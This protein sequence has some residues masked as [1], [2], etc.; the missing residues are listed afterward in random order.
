MSCKNVIFSG[1]QLIRWTMTGEV[2]PVH[3]WSGHSDM[4]GGLSSVSLRATARWTRPSKGGPWS[5]EKFRLSLEVEKVG[6]P[7]KAGPYWWQEELGSQRRSSVEDWK[8]TVGS[9]FALQGTPLKHRKGTGSCKEITI[10]DFTF[11]VIS[12]YL[13]KT[14]QLHI[15]SLDFACLPG[16]NPRRW[17]HPLSV[18]WLPMRR[19]KGTVSSHI[20]RHL[21]SHRTISSEIDYVL[22]T[23]L[24]LFPS[25]GLLQCDQKRQK[26]LFYCVLPSGNYGERQKPYRNV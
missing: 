2:I 12:Q 25:E 21:P 14:L 11:H 19:L 24:V 1:I 3:H 18:D 8:H 10:H 16:K 5:V 13:N 26:L 7:W 15:L 20:D 22:S 23:S 9:W 6:L 4:R 17:N